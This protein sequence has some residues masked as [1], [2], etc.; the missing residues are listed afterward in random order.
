MPMEYSKTV[1][2]IGRGAKALDVARAAFIS[3]GFQILASSDTELRV[4]GPGIN[5]TREN[6]LKG[7]SDA[8]IIVR[9]SSIEARAVLGGAQ[10][11]KTFLRVFPLGLALFFMIV[12]GALALSLPEFRRIWIFLIPL[13]SLSPWL[14]LAPLMGRSIEN[15]TKQAV[16]TLLSNMVVMGKEG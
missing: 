9:G 6:P 10:K 4:K 5:S 11:M 15:R 8:S 13:L 1:P 2:F 16:D 3:Q 12:F 14:F 7:I